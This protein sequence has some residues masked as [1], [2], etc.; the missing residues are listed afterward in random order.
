MDVHECIQTRRSLRK[1][2]TEAID[3][4]KLLRVLEAVRWAP[5][6][7]NFQPWEVVVVDDPQVKAALQDCVT[8]GNPGRKSIPAVIL[9]FQLLLLHNPLLK[10]GST[11]YR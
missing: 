11:V 3:E 9:Y 10:L 8:E 4:Q 7:V 6:W 5:S 1:Y 2:E